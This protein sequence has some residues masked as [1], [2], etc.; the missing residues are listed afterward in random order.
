MTDLTNLN[1]VA[2]QHMLDFVQGSQITPMDS[3]SQSPI[4]VPIVQS[5]PHG[6]GDVSPWGPGTACN[7]SS[8][9]HT[10]LPGW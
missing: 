1:R 5:Q 4:V 3:V 2:S 9:L 7:R 10:A 6:G 8:P